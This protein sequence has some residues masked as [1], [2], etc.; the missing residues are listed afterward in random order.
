MTLIKNEKLA[1]GTTLAY[2]D[3]SKTITG[4]RLFVRLSC[5]VLVPLCAWMEEAINECGP[6]KDFFK[7]EIK[8]GLQHELVWERNFVDEKDKDK[9]MDD[10]MVRAQDIYGYLSND[11]FAIRLFH[12]R[13]AELKEERLCQVGIVES[14]QDSDLIEEGPADFSDCFK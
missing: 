2:T 4:D 9:C 1:N 11:E 3:E 7:N 8:D 5:T 6:E 10:L 12:K 14:T 13:L